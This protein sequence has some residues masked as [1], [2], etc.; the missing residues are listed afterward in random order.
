MGGGGKGRG[1]EGSERE[2]L[3]T[4]VHTSVHS[5][6]HKSAHDAW[7]H[8][9]THT[10]VINGVQCVHSVKKPKTKP[11]GVPEA[12]ENI[13]QRKIDHEKPPCPK[14]QCTGLNL[15]REG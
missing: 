1:V 11:R 14:R 3:F 9:H 6:E 15:R 13:K 2:S 10:C 8:V 4:T 12:I 5:S 7:T